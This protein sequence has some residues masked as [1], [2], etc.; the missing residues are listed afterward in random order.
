MNAFWF[1][2][3]DARLN[4]FMRDCNTWHLANFQPLKSLF[5]RVLVPFTD[6]P[7]VPSLAEADPFA[8][9]ANLAVQEHTLSGLRPPSPVK[10]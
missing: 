6:A 3:I 8:S 9:F 10:E 1:F 4:Q 2:M 5:N 7:L